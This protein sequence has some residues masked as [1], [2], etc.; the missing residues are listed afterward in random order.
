MRIARARPEQA[1]IGGDE[2]K[3]ASVMRSQQ[4][5]AGELAV[6]ICT[7]LVQLN[8]PELPQM[9]LCHVLHGAVDRKSLS[10]SKF[11][12]S[13]EI[14]PRAQMYFDFREG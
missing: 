5:W 14:F 3:Q 7:Q 6:A 2:D 4:W 11:P 8:G 12:V 13:W 10:A 9:Q 1:G